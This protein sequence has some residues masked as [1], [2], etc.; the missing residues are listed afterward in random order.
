MRNIFI[1]FEGGEGAGKTTQINLLKNYLEKNNIVVTM[2]REPGGDKISE[3]IRDIIKSPNN[4][5]MSVR[6]ELLLFSAA[7]AQNVDL[8]IKPAL[9]KGDVV[10]CDRFY[11]SSIVYQGYGRGIGEKKVKEITKFAVEGLEPT[12][13]FYLNIDPKIA[14]ARKG[15]PDNDRLEI[16]GDAFH[17]I[18]R[19][20]YLHLAKKEKRIKVIDANQSPQKVFEDILK[21]VK[22]VFIK[23]IVSER[24]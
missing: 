1:T 22:S 2:T 15:G 14:F 20:G 11:D 8:V 6:A 21:Q 24:S 16:A 3:Q 13:T 7:R 17:E 9:K 23:E 18:I 4:G 10:I 5:I 19:E 12:L